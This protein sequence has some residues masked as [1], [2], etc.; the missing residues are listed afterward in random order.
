MTQITGVV[1]EIRA[2]PVAGGKIAYDVVVGGEGYGAGLYAP[3]CKQGDYVQ[4]ELDDSRGY[5]NVARNTL[6]VS[7]NKAPAEAVAVAASTL[8]PRASTGA[9]VDS[10][11]DVISRQAA[12][13]SALQFLAVLASTDSLGLPKTD[14]KGKRMEALETMLTKYQQ[15]FYENNTGVKW[16]D[17]SPS[18]KEEAEATASDESDA[19]ADSEWE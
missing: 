3:K 4:F 5:K 9:L 1:Q 2:K 19:P 6:K 10:R 12:L 15:D 13:N 18:R 8:P 14:T 16:K 11:Q 17:I 7:K